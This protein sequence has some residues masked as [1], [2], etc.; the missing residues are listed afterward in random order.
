MGEIMASELC[1]ELQALSRRALEA[2]SPA[3][4]LRRVLKRGG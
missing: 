1:G 3:R 2:V 4:F